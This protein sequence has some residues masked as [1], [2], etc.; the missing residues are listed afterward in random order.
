MLT[1]KMVN[2][3]HQDTIGNLMKWRRIVV[4][5]YLILIAQF[6]LQTREKKRVFII[7]RRKT[8]GCLTRNRTALRCLRYYV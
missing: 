1:A 4:C 3:I 8:R 7:K 2:E 5:I 6:I